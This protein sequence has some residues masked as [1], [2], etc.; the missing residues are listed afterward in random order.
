MKENIIIFLCFIS[1]LCSCD[2]FVHQRNESASDGISP[3]ID[4]LDVWPAEG[5]ELLWKYEGLGRGYGGPMVSTDGIFINEEKEGMSYTIK[6]DLNGTVIWRSPNGKEFIGTDYSASYPG[7]R[8][9]PTVIG[10]HVYAVSGTGHMSCFDSST[11]NV[12]WAVDLITD[13]NGILGEFGYSESPTVDENSVYCFPGGKANNIVALDRLTGELVWS[14]P[15]KKDYFSYGTPILLNLPNRNVLVGTSRNYIHVVDRQ[16]GKLLSSYQLEDIKE[17]NEHCNSVV[18]QDGYIFFVP[19]E[20]HG[21]GTIKLLLSSDGETLS[22]VWRNRKVINV[23]EGFVVVDNWLYT[24]LENKKL[25]G[26]D[27]NTGRIRNSVRAV[28]G[29]I[30]YA[31]SKLFVYGHNGIVQL[32]SLDGENPELKSEMRVSDGN[33]HHFSFPVIADGV[34]YIRRG[35]ALMAYAVQ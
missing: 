21:Q 32:F 20:K 35:D 34:M 4:L 23:F 27:T 13:F 17:G 24:T 25:V 3:G 16:D 6:L 11:G 12:I 2:I 1:V 15:V 9:V 7:T 22:E 19:F 33:G 31:D 30:V 5:P 14:A 18:Y 29:S 26:L 10:R 28:S 8:S